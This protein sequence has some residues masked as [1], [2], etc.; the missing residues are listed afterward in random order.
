MTL[1]ERI[2]TRLETNI[3]LATELANK[4]SRSFEEGLR[5]YKLMARIQADTAA[6]NREIPAHLIRFAA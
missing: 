3:A 4:Q 2:A 5:L 6:L 1:R